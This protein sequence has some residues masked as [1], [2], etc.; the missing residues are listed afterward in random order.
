MHVGENE[1]ER[2]HAFHLDQRQ[3]PVNQQNDT[4][5]Y[6]IHATQTLNT[7]L[8]PVNGPM[9]IQSHVLYQ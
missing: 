6:T 2:R 4:P 9:P 8:D 7:K 3:L 1:R 5:L